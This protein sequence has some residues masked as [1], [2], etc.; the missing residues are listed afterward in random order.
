[1]YGRMIIKT[2]EGEEA[3]YHKTI[4]DFKSMKALL[5]STGFTNI[6]R[7]DWRQT[8]HKDY[9]DFSQAYLPHMNKEN[10]TLMSLNVECN[11]E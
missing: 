1:M 4:Y 6:H 8:V 2:P 5:E 3:I 11:K 10:G 7:Y 9:D